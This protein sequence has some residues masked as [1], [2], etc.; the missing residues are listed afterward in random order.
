MFLDHHFAVGFLWFD[1]F[2]G[3]PQNRLKT[4]EE[5]SVRSQALGISWPCEIRTLCWAKRSMWGDLGP[6][7]SS[8]SKEQLD[9]RS[10]SCGGK[11]SRTH[12]DSVQAAHKC[13]PPQMNH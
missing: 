6:L 10:S 12:G 2:P 11:T 5:S 13:E 9:L 3:A 7:G 4:Q 1:L 8:W